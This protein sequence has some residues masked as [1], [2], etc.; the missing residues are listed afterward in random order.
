VGGI[1]GR[2]QWFIVVNLLFNASMLV[3]LCAWL[4]SLFISNT[5]ALQSYAGGAALSLLHG[6]YEMRHRRI[7]YDLHGPA[8]GLPMALGQ[9]Q[10]GLK[11][12]LHR[13]MSFL[14][15]VLLWP[16]RFLLVAVTLVYKIRNKSGVAPEGHIAVLF[17]KYLL[18]VPVLLVLSA[19]TYNEV[20]S[21]GY[22]LLATS[23]TVATTLCAILY[24]VVIGIASFR[25]Y[26]SA[27]L[28]HPVVNAALIAVQLC[29]IVIFVVAD[30]LP[31]TQSARHSFAEGATQV[32]SFSKLGDAVEQTILGFFIGEGTISIASFSLVILIVIGL[33]YLTVIKALSSGLIFGRTDSGKLAVANYFRSAGHF[34]RAN[35]LIKSV[36]GKNP[37]KQSLILQIQV[38][39]GQEA[40]SFA[41][42]ARLLKLIDAEDNG[43][44]QAAL[45]AARSAALCWGR[46][47][48]RERASRWR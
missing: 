35:D 41:T 32:F 37:I 25:E 19:I 48:N 26:V 9:S 12:K 45:V 29:L 11:G 10:G 46:P 43:E 28:T 14:F 1:Q 23:F 40:G 42:A 47:E 36:D 33:F 18:H 8:S 13:L 7:V 20:S 16:G 27:N 44:N 24:M 30:L 22:T 15:L 34:Q 31:F 17:P 4:V 21:D 39:Q 3:L 38:A 5:A 2:Q 6:L